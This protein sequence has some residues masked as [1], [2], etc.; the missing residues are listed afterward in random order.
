MKTPASG[1]KRLLQRVAEQIHDEEQERELG[2]RQEEIGDAHERV[3]HRAARHGRRSAPT[4]VPTVMA[5]S[6]A[7]TP[8][9][10]EMRPP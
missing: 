9:A 4:A 1:P 7:A 5:M 2:Q 10:S 6:M 3:I 8:T